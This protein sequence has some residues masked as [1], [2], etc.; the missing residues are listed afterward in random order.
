MLSEVKVSLS[1]AVQWLVVYPVEGA[2]M[3]DY[4]LIMN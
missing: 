3:N 2:V 4:T 1:F